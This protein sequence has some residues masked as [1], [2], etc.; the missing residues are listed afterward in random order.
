MGSGRNPSESDV[1][2]IKHAGERGAALTKQILA[3][4]RRQAL[5]P[6]VVCL[7]DVLSGMESLLRRSLGEDIELVILLCPDLGQSEVD[8]HQF[9]QVLMNLAL[10]ARDAMPA[11]G[12][13]LLETGNAEF[14]E[15]DCAALPDTPPGSYVMLS[16]SDTGIGMDAETMSHVFEPFFTTKAPDQGT[17]SRALHRLRHRAPERGEH[18]R[19]K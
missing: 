7:N 16:V 3:F 1:E 6:E 18:K 10:N 9:E 2:E 15:E 14:D 4:S 11:G 5:K 8:P 12:R 13:L 17:G 19:P